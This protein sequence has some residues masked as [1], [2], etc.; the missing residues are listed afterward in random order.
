MGNSIKA[1]VFEFIYD[2]AVILPDNRWAVDVNF[3][4]IGDHEKKVHSE[5]VYTLV[6]S[7]AFR[8]D[9]TD[10]YRGY[11]DEKTIV[12]DFLDK[13]EVEKKSRTGHT[14]G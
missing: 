10:E 14:F 2:D 8:D 9:P 4:L 6:C 5:S 12:M 13:T 1:K 3:R 7:P 11:I